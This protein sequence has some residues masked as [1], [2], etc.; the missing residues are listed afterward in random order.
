[1]TRVTSADVAREA[2]LSR[3]TVSYVLNDDPRQRIPEPTRKRVLEAAERLGYLPYGPAR[4]LRGGR[5]KTVLLLTPSVPEAA[6]PVGSGIIAALAD[7]LA[8]HDLRL[9]WQ[10]GSPDALAAAVGDLAPAVVLTSLGTD[11]PDFTDLVQRIR[12]P[13]LPAF[14]GLDEFLAA[15]GRAQVEYLAQRHSR[16]VFAEPMDPGLDRLV[17]LRRE[18]VLATAVRLGLAPPMVVRIP[19]D[20]TGAAVRL[21]ELVSTQPAPTAV[22][23][24]NDR[25]A[26]TVLAG[27]ADAGISVPSELAV[28]GVDD[29]P[30]A[31]LVTPALSS[32]TADIAPFVTALADATAAAA[33]GEPFAPVLLP[34]AAVVVPRASG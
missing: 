24:Y 2:G 3:A 7:A 6:Q 5:S 13:L 14:A 34:A 17:A 25:V 18:A 23:A 29:D 8:E 9:L 11:E 28:V 15:S 21:H 1:M 12:V 19:E 16:L 30:V 26:F 4:L 10:L 31:P 33:T 20:R 22:C 32:V 27:A